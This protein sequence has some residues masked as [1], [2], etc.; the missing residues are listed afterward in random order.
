MRELPNRETPQWAKPGARWI[1]WMCWPMLAV[2]TA[3]LVWGMAGNKEPGKLFS[4]ACSVLVFVCVLVHNHVVRR[5][6]RRQ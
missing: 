2:S 1:P 6:N 3:L 5:R 4:P